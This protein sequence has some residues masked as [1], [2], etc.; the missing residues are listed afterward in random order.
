MDVYALHSRS[1]QV[2]GWDF[3]W[4]SSNQSSRRL[5]C[6]PEWRKSCHRLLIKHRAS[7]EC[8]SAFHVQ[9]G[10]EQFVSRNWPCL[11][12][13]VGLLRSSCFE[14]QSDCHHLLQ[15]ELCLHEQWVY[16]CR[17]SSRPSC[18]MRHLFLLPVIHFMS[19]FSIVQTSEH[20]GSWHHM[21]EKLPCWNGSRSCPSPEWGTQHRMAAAWQGMSNAA[22]RVAKCGRYSCQ[23]QLA[24]TRPIFCKLVTLP[25]LASYGI[26]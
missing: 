12:R 7:F 25:C 8:F 2:C 18:R 26:L 24:C 13:T 5:L 16:F 1:T 20:L 23:S 11:F 22:V 9:F 4:L 19:Y 15:I 10:R 6:R 17:M 14:S 3:H 21:S